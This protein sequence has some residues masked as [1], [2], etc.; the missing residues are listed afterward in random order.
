M[1]LNLLGGYASGEPGGQ[2]T[3]HHTVLTGMIISLKAGLERIFAE[4]LDNVYARHAAAGRALQDGLEE[5]G[6]TLFA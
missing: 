4:G 1:D 2:R 6:L 5:M 3:Y